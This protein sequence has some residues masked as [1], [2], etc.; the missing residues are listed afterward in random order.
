MSEAFGYSGVRGGCSASLVEKDNLEGHNL[1]IP[2]TLIFCLPQIYRGASIVT[3]LNSQR[4]LGWIQCRL[5]SS[6]KL[7]ID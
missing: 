2:Q 6:I 3:A 1:L 7:L 4:V 5:D